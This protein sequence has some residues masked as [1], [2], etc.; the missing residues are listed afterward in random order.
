[1]KKIFIAL[2]SV[3]FVFTACNK[4]LDTTN[5][6]KY[7]TSTF[8]ASEKDAGQVIVGCYQPMTKLYT[9][10]ENTVV[11]RNMLVS[12]DLYGAGSTSNTG[13]QATDRLMEKGTDESQTNWGRL[14]QG[15]FR[16]N[17]ALE[18]IPEMDDALFSSADAKNYLIGQAYFLRA[19]YNWNL[20]EYFETFPLLTATT[21]ANNPRSSVDEIYEAIAGDLTN[22]ID[23][24]PASHKYST[25]D[26]EA[27]RATKYAAEAVLA[28][29][30]MFYTG[31]YGKSDM[32]GVSKSQIITYLK[33]VRDNSGFGL[34][35]DPREIWPYTNEYSSGIAYGADFET[36]SNQEDLHWVGNKCKETVWGCHFSYVAY[37]T[38]SFGYNR[39]GEYCGLRNSASAP[40]AKTYPYGIGYTNGTVNPKL[41]Q[42]W[43]EDPDYGPSDKRLWGSL[44]AVDNAEERLPWMAGQYVELAKHDG[45]DSKE[46]EKSM[47]HNKKYMV[48]V[49]Y[50]DATKSQLY[51]NFFYA[52]P[53]FSGSNSNQYDNRNDVIYVRYADVLLMLDELEGTVTGMNQLR[54]R[55]GL[56]PYASYSFENLQKERRYEL[57]FEGLRWTDLR[58]WY[59]T[60]AGKIITDNQ[61]GGFIEYRGNAVPGGYTQIADRNFE[62]RYAATR[63]FWKI[64]STQISLSNDTLTETPGWEID[65]KN[66]LFSNGNLPYPTSY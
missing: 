10:P 29:I 2:L 47:F 42:E 46:V 56:A 7:D 31:F 48:S 53:G 59:P 30:W 66:W 52:I 58:R 65:S 34:V 43:L 16:T 26:G 12:D 15:I 21:V 9:D 13:A 50:S 35:D 54:A 23:L 41:V 19:W 17:F 24:M 39:I 55:A 57:C 32:F 3:A 14:Y 61:E 36:Y 63:G 28:R 5:Y 60:T 22:A 49:A 27:G 37:S 11:F 1:M 45:N 6:S 44:Y 33:D 40:N 18:S 8:P 4:M 38:G 62:T 20:A 51:K 25:N 64:S